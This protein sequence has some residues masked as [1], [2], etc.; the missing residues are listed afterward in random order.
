[1]LYLALFM[2][3]RCWAETLPALPSENTPSAHKL[4]FASDNSSQHFDSWTIDSGYAYNVFEDIDLY[5]G[6]RINNNKQGENG[7]LSG[8]RYQFT[9]RLSFKSTL[10]S[11]ANPDKTKSKEAALSA[12]L[13]SR[14]KLSEN[15]DLHA[16]LDYQEWQ[17]GVEFGIGFRF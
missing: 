14:L 12:E 15:L 8:I 4:F 16:T 5:V 1:M 10:L 2:S 6:A 3:P 17:Q 11:T 9:E 13:S 7:W